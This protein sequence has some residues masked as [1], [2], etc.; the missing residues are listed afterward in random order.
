MDMGWDELAIASSLVTGIATLG[1]ALFLSVQLRVQHKDSERLHLDSERQFAFLNE[2]RQQEL[3]ISYYSDEST[4]NLFWKGASDFDALTEAEENRYRMMLHSM[5]FHLV[6]AWK[7][8]RDGS[9]LRRLRSSWEATLRHPG[10]RRI[11]EKSGRSLLSRDPEIVE[12]VEE[13]YN[14]LESQAA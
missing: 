9:D 3:F 14:E 5:Y 6:N 2:N 12:F 1:V 13:I 7:L 4:A 11:Y 10:Q 8:E